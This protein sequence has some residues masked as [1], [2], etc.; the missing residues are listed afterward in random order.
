[1]VER[2]DHHTFRLHTEKTATP[3][4]CDDDSNLNF[5]LKRFWDLESIKITTTRDLLMTPGE[6][7]AWD[8]ENKSIKFDEKPITKLLSLG[9]KIDRDYKTTCNRQRNNCSPREDC[10][11]INQLPLPIT[12]SN[13]YQDVEYI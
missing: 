6:K 3:I 13:E 7:L 5:I 1:M 12:E 10:Y 2:Q 9:D 11:K 4:I 8:N